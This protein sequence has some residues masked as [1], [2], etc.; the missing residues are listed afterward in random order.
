MPG[1]R[2]ASHI[3]TP[4]IYCRGVRGSF[5]K[6]KGARSANDEI[7]LLAPVRGVKDCCGVGCVVRS[8]KLRGTRPLRV[9]VSRKWHDRARRATQPK[10]ASRVPT[11][12]RSCH[13]I[14]ELARPCAGPGG[15]R[16]FKAG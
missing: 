15:Q 16:N 6:K 8:A 4:F 7:A 14:L 5:A 13:F 10:A 2:R 11:G 3:P 12:A 1:P 9:A